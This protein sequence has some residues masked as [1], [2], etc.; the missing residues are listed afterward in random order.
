MKGCR[1]GVG[2]YRRTVAKRKKEKRASYSGGR[3][4]ETREKRKTENEA[5]KGVVD[6]E[7]KKPSAPPIHNKG[8]KVA[9][10]KGTQEERWRGKRRT[11]IKKKSTRR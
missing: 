3:K 5:S 1:L 2:C 4:G 7:K 9:K 6:M 10:P 8:G 11:K